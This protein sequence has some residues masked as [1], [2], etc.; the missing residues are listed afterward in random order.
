MLTGKQQLADDTPVPDGAKGAVFAHESEHRP[1]MVFN[2]IFGL[3]TGKIITD[4][5]HERHPVFDQIV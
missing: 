2:S 5:A 4:F 3:E 1:F